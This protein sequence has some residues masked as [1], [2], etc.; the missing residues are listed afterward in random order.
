LDRRSRY[1]FAIALIALVAVAGGAAMV[2][3]SG[4]PGPSGTDLSARGVIV[5]IE[6][7]GL[8]RIRSFRLRTDDAQ[9]LEF[10]IG[11]LQTV[12]TFPPGHLAEHQATAQPVRVWYV[13]RGA[14][15]VAVRLE[16]AP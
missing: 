9:T 15:N 5:G 12:G 7:E 13:R 3:S 11:V 6:S 4:E 1:L 16:D 2:S 8:D 14:L 10:D